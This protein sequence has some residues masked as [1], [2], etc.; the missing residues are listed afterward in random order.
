MIKPGDTV[1][2]FSRWRP[3]R[4]RMEE[5]IHGDEIP[6]APYYLCESCGDLWLSLTEIGY[7]IAP[8]ENVPAL[9]EELKK[10][11]EVK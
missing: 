7:C 9:I 5:R 8:D 6:L 10:Y 3:T 2:K 1:L 11:K 4:N